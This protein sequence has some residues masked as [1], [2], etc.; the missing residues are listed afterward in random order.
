MS[1]YLSSNSETLE[2]I[3]RVILIPSYNEILALP[4]LLKELNPQLTSADAVLVVDDSAQEVFSEIQ[5]ASINAMAGS[6]GSIFFSN[7]SGKSGRGAAVRRGMKIATENLPNLISIMECDADGSHQ[8]GDIIFIKSNPLICDLLV[9]SRYLK[10]SKIQGWPM[11]RRLF[12]YLLNISIPRALGIP[13]N[14]ITN[15]LRRYSMPAIEI[16]LKSEQVNKGFTYLSEQALLIHR[17]GLS[18]EECPITFIDRTLGSSTVTWREILQ[19][20]KGIFAL[21]SFKKDYSQSR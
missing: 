6:K 1:D 4:A 3:T 19:S 7:E 8:P 14:D 21:I 16:I 15:G 12:S 11:S 20:I 5:E 2:K 13:I 9:G 18:I 17:A 10:E